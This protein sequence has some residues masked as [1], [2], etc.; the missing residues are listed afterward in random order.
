MKNITVGITVNFDI[1]FHA[2]GL[3]QNIVFLNKLLTKLDNIDPIYI[4]NGIIPNEDF[5]NKKK[6]VSYKEYIENRYTDFDLII[7]MGFWL[8]QNSINKIKDSRNTKFVFLQCGN[9]FIENSM[10]S[11]HNYDKVDYVNN[12]LIGIDAIWILPQHSQNK[13]FMQVFYRVDNVME[14]PCIWDS[15]FVDKQFRELNQEGENIDLFRKDLKK[16]IILEPNLSIIKNCLLPIYIVESFE[17]KFPNKLTSCSII[18]GKKIVESHYF[19]RLIMQLDIFKKRENFIKATNRYKFYEAVKFF[20]SV[21][22]SHQIENDLN[23][24]YFDAL[25]LNLPLIHNSERLKKY[26]YFYPHNNIDLAVD[27]LKRVIDYHE[28]NIIDYKLKNKQLIDSFSV[29]NITNQKIYLNLINQVMKS[30]D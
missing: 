14:A 4:Y 22:I 29:N 15:I 17:R 23:Y 1:E 7:L 6:C 25:Y 28:E 26:G 18:S 21:I 12:Y 9:Q 13:T 8:G 16:I 10:R 27:N 30:K 20:G 2:N 3:Q 5:I 24:L 11:V 19:M